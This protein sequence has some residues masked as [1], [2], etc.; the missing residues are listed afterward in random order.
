MGKSKGS[1]REKMPATAAFI[2]EL[3]R[4]FGKDEIDSI[5]R[6]AMRGEPDSF[7]AVE[8]GFTFGVKPGPCDR[9]KVMRFSEKQ[10]CWVSYD[11]WEKE[12]NGCQG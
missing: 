12:R 11:T 5:L 7:Y 6:K 9:S 4:V 3:R 8:N 1:L 2:D 10:G